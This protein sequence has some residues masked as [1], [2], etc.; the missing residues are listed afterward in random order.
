MRQ[1]D[2]ELEWDEET[3]QPTFYVTE[4][5]SMRWKCD[6]TFITD[7]KDDD[8]ERDAIVEQAKKQD[9]VVILFDGSDS[10]IIASMKD[11][12]RS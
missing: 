2:V 11:V 7:W 4:D 5:G 3:D 1:I 6:D 9:E 8:G 10:S 12:I